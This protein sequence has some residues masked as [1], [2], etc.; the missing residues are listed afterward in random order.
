AYSD[1]VAGRGFHVSQLA[2][3][4]G[5]RVR[6]RQARDLPRLQVDGDDLPGLGVGTLNGE[7]PMGLDADDVGERR[8]GIRHLA[9]L[10]GQ[11]EVEDRAAAVVVGRDEEP[12]RV[13][14]PGERG[15]PAVPVAAEVS[16]VPAV[17]V[18]HPYVQIRGR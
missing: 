1:P 3:Q 18:H 5:P 17:G 12:G 9:Y 11:G 6:V 10:T 16:G 4:G 2:G 8:I 7:S 13:G 15:G 14:Q